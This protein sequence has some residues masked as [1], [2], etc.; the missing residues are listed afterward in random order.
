[1]G[2]DGGSFPH[3]EEMVKEKP[4]EYK[5]D[6]ALQAQAKSRIWTISS[7]N[8][9]LPLVADRIGNIFN[10]EVVLKKLVEKSIPKSYCYITKMKDV[11]ELNVSTKKP[12]CATIDN[13]GE[14]LI[15]CPISAVEFDGY[16]KFTLLWSCG[17]VIAT[18]V[19][20]NMDV[21]KKC[22]ICGEK[23][24]KK[25]VIDLVPDPKS[26]EEQRRKLVQEAVIKKHGLKADKEDKKDETE[27]TVLG[28]R[29]REE[30]AKTC[31]KRQKVDDVDELL[32]KEIDEEWRMKSKINDN[33]YKYKDEVER[34]LK[35]KLEKDDTFKSLFGD[36]CNENRESDYLCRSGYGMK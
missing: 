31:N 14:N 21:D 24:K 30:E 26:A 17:W 28:K 9:T 12:D 8:L 18:K 19:F 10:K 32:N 27:G 3:R 5:A 34:K 23:F 7:Q 35:E 29:V 2:N 25:H 6:K 1:M 22:P 33:S 16:H 15:V 4:K 13:K 11:K 36:K 20:E